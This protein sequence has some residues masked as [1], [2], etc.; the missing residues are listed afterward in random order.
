LF[1]DCKLRKV[2]KMNE[3]N[4]QTQKQTT[5]VKQRHQENIAE[6]NMMC[7]A[8]TDLLG[9]GVSERREKIYCPTRFI[10][11]DYTMGRRGVVVD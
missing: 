10:G 4:T 9:L 2:L 1:D 11:E 8:S 7:L 3:D 5:A 6:P